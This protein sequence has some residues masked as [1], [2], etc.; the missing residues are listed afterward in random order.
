MEMLWKSFFAL[1]TMDLFGRAPASTEIV[2][3]V[4]HL[5]N[6]LI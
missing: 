4:A 5:V 3:A 2:P 1:E 6:Q